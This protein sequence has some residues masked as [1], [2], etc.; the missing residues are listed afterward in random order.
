MCRVR[1][2]PQRYPS[3]P[4]P[5]R[6]YD[7]C[8]RTQQ[9]GPDLDLGPKSLSSGLPLYLPPIPTLHWLSETA[10]AYVSQSRS[11]IDTAREN[12]RQS[13]VSTIV[14]LLRLL[15]HVDPTAHISSHVSCINN[16][17]TNTLGSCPTLLDSR[18]NVGVLHLLVNTSSPLGESILNKVALV[19]ASTEEDCVDT[20]QN[21]GAL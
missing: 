20:E 1:H 4:T 15:L 13:D 17:L 16:L 11:C 6:A 10:N 12:R 8:P 19:E 7:L 9:H 21:P 14:H 3:P 18:W 2:E 5:G